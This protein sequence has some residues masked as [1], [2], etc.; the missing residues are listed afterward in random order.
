MSETIKINSIVKTNGYQAIETFDPTTVVLVDGYTYGYYQYKKYRLISNDVDFY[1][2]Y[3]PGKYPTLLISFKGTELVKYENANFQIVIDYLNKFDNLSKEQIEEL[4]I[5][6]QEVSKTQ[7]ALEIE[8]L[9]EEKEKLQ[10]Q[11]AIL[12]QIEEKKEELRQLLT[13]LKE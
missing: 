7:L 10:E 3:E 6:A 9:M 8:A 13:K 12:Q 1:W 2:D 5:E 11:V 4:V